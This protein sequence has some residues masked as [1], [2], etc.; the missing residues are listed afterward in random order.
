VQERAKRWLIGLAP[1]A[2]YKSGPKKGQERPREETIKT[3]SKKLQDRKTV[4]QAGE[5]YK[6]SPISGVY[7]KMLTSGRLDQVRTRLS[8]RAAA[9]EAYGYSGMSPNKAEASKAVLK[10][11]REFAKNPRGNQKLPA[12]SMPAPQQKRA[13]TISE[14]PRRFAPT[15]K[16]STQSAPVSGPK[17]SA[18]Q[19]SDA[20]YAKRKYGVR[21]TISSPGRKSQRSPRRAL[22]SGQRVP[23]TGRTRKQV[24]RAYA[25]TVTNK[26]FDNYNRGLTRNA[27]PKLRIAKQPLYDQFSVFG[28][29]GTV[30]RTQVTRARS[31]RKPK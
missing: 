13:N 15:A 23:I 31:R 6:R 18:F 11:A 20:K 17:L 16:P 12:L 3:L 14:A 29:S 4:K 9:R 2:T 26:L 5:A 25:K 24:Q 1:T 8:K 27:G 30:S 19:R 7:G 22:Q 10:R 28:G 21:S